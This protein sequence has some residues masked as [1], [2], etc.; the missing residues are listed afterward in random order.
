M[1]TPADPK[2]DLLE[3]LA[4]IGGALAS[5]LRLA[6]LELLAQGERTVDELARRADA[7]VANTSQHLQRLKAAGLVL[8]RSDGPYVRYRLASDGVVT[9]LGALSAAGRAHLAD[10]ETA[11]R[12]YVEARDTLEPV[13]PDELL[14]RAKR[15]LVTVLDVRPAEE[16][17]VGHLPGA[18]NI[19]VGE[20]QRRLRELP[21]NREVVAYCRGPW[22]LMSFDAVALLRKKGLRARR[23]RDGLPEWRAAGLPVTATDTPRR[24]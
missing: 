12:D 18:V 9:L 10:V 2:R 13:A 3:A 20:L 6:I 1:S 14:E 15:G 17:A 23:L 8:A 19:P 11:V 4:R 21:R 7:S 24:A 22:C 16:F 5:P